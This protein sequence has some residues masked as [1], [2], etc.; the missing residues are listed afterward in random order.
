MRVI[1][2][3]KLAD[4]VDG[5]DLTHCDVGDVLDLAEP[6]ARAIVAE[7]WAV[8]ARR[9]SDSA[10]SSIPPSLSDAI[11]AAGRRFGTDRRQTWS[12]NDLYNRLRDKREEIE[13]ERRR[14][15]RRAADDHIA[16]RRA[17]C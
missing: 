3:R 1:V 11:L 6:D 15:S 14:L 10:T 17:D 8:P 13:R 5:I 4:R 7:R 9:R 12:A 16:G 2:V